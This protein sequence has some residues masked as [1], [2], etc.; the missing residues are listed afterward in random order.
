VQRSKS[1]QKNFLD[2]HLQ[3]IFIRFQIYTKSLRLPRSIN[4]SNFL[5]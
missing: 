2:L 5:N 4:I 3:F 1:D